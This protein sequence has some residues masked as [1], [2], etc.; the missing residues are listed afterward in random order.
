MKNINFFQ[1]VWGKTVETVVNTIVLGAKWL[2]EEHTGVKYPV[3]GGI[4]KKILFFY[5]YSPKGGR[6]GLGKSEISLSEKTEIFL[7]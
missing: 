5:D 2:F 4:K 3:R 7:A 1:S 6:G